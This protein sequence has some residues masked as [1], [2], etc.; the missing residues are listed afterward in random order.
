MHARQGWGGGPSQRQKEQETEDP[1]QV[2]HLWA[3]KPNS[4]LKLTNR[5]HKVLD[6]G[7]KFN[8]LSHPGNPGF[9]WHKLVYMHN[10]GIVKKSSV[11]IRHASI[12]NHV[13][14]N[15]LICLSLSF[16][17]YKMEQFHWMVYLDTYVVFCGMRLL[18]FCFMETNT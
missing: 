17:T 7:Q 12:N 18:P 10:L 9:S 4:G 8:R 13:R 15:L 11:L 14:L 6:W 5:V 3:T 16:I 2:L 1:K